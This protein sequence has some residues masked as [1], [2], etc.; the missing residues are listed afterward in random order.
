MDKKKLEKIIEELENSYPYVVKDLV[1]D[2]K[3]VLED[4][5]KGVWRAG[6]GEWYHYVDA[7]GCIAWLPD[8]REAENDF[9]YLTGNYFKTSRGGEVH[10][11]YLMALG[12][13]RHYI[14]ENFPFEPD[15]ED[16]QEKWYISYA[17]RV[18]KFDALYCEKFEDASLLPYL[19]TERRA[20]QVIKDCEADLKIIFKITKQ[21]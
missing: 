1:T 15:W 9:H 20:F 4:K 6:E 17:H 19:E 2:L 12:R 11:K 14:L 5:P 10:K 8:R 21:K 7:D 16:E 13:V 3:S 18:K